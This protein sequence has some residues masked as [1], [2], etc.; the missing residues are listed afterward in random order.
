MVEELIEAVVP[1]GVWVAMGVAIGAAFGERLRPVAKEA[2]K[3][4]MTMAERLQ[5][6][7][8]EA[9]EKAQDLVAEARYEQRRETGN[10]RARAAST[11]RRRATERVA[12][13]APE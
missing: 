4:G 1:G 5:E 6:A 9:Y 2:I 12:S 7:G 8:A 10:G 13:P 3:T 11:R